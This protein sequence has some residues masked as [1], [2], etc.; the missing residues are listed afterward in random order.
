MALREVGRREADDPRRLAGVRDEHLRPV[1]DVLVAAANGGR[2]DPGD[3]GA[4]TRLGEPEAA[5]ERSLEQRP[6]PL[7]LLLLA[8]GDENR[9]GGEPVRPDRR[10]DT[11][12][13]PVQLLP[14][15]HPVEAR[16]LG[17][18]ERLRQVQVHQPDLVRFGDDVGGMNLTFVAD[19]RPRPDLLLCERASERAQLALFVGQPER[20]SRA[21]TLLDC[22]HARRLLNVVGSKID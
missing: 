9:A 5:E 17:T 16:E 4:R 15:E 6:E 2:L 19:G 1:D 13:P 22:C 7:L 20:D 14:D 18:A 3:V 8:A 10:A 11:R 12:A 21:G